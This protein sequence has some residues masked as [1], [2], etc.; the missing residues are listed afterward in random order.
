VAC[1]AGSAGRCGAL[2]TRP[3]SHGPPDALIDS[4]PLPDLGQTDKAG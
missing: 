3:A 4:T 2:V 1:A